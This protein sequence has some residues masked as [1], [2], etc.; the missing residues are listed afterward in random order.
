MR[1]YEMLK[2]GLQKRT[3]TTLRCQLDVNVKMRM[4]IYLIQRKKRACEYTSSNAKNVHAN[5]PH[6]TQKTCMRIYLI[7]RKKR[8]CEYTSSNSKNVHASRFLSFVNG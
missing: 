2:S 7:Q 3:E 8:A 4:R 1:S 6:P 5:I